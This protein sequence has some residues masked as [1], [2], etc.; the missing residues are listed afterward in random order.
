M[1]SA[2]HVLTKETVASLSS[3]EL[4]ELAHARWLQVKQI[5]H[6]ELK[7]PELLLD[8]A[9]IMACNIELHN[10]VHLDEEHRGRP[11]TDRQLLEHYRK[12]QK[13]RQEF[14]S[15][16]EGVRA[17]HLLRK[18]GALV[19]ELDTLATAPNA[20]NTVAYYARTADQIDELGEAGLQQTAAMLPDI[21][22]LLQR[23][24]IRHRPPPTHQTGAFRRLMPPLRSISSDIAPGQ[25]RSPSPL[26]F[27]VPQ[28]PPSERALGRAA[29]GSEGRLRQQL[30][31]F[32]RQY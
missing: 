26:R 1:A 7:T 27:E 25:H 3:G 5:W 29:L 19:V 14:V 11:P 31:Y 28:S 24:V 23:P 4:V 15:S 17:E 20:D 30:I 2:S 21:Q 8:A 32:G 18:V 10:L 22:R 13:A 12:V 9:K 16:A 6:E